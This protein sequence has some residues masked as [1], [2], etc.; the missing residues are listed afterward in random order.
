[1]PGDDT[2]HHRDDEDVEHR[3]GGLVR[4]DARGVEGAPVDCRSDDQPGGGGQ[5]A[6]PGATAPHPT[7][8][9]PTTRR[10]GSVPTA[11]IRVYTPSPAVKTTL[12]WMKEAK[13]PASTGWWSSWAGSGSS[14]AM[15]RQMPI[16]ARQIAAVVPRKP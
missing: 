16:S 4:A 7:V 9:A 11:H 14:A 3:G 6:E 5:S 10:A 13:P 2:H 15:P 8:T 1:M 12:Q